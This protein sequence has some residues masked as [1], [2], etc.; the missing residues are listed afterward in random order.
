M[1]R[2]NFYNFKWDR[3]KKNEKA[4]KIW[5]YFRTKTRKNGKKHGNIMARF[6]TWQN[7][8]V[9]NRLTWQSKIF[10]WQPWVQH[11]NR[12]AHP[13]PPLSIGDSVVIQPP[14][15]KRWSTPGSIGEV[16]PFRDYLVKTPAG[17]LFRRNR[18][19]LRGI[20]PRADRQLDPQPASASA[21]QAVAQPAFR[22]AR[23]HHQPVPAAHVA[24]PR[25]RLVNASL[26]SGT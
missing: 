21:R 6:K 20:V 7:C 19:F 13:L 15:T 5:G 22:S 14:I 12:K 18:R 1:F 23:Q 8:H 4:T 17:R 26:M 9:L 24:S 2:G 16:G 10:Q 25:G 11:Y 3:G